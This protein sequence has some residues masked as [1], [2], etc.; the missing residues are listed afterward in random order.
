VVALL[1]VALAAGCGS[2]AP[3]PVA[4]AQDR[5]IADAFA[6]HSSGVSVSGGGTVARVL[7]DDTSGDRHQRFILRLASGQTVL[8]AHNIDIA[9]RVEGLA[10]GDAIE[11][12]GQFEF[13]DEGG[14]VHWTH[15]DPSGNHPAGWLRVDG[16]VYQ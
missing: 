12:S 1:L 15:H 7:P 3:A 5:A 4:S 16:S 8:I 10:V 9:P 14:T 13:N 11:F 6:A 2:T